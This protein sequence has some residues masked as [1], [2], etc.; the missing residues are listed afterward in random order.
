MYKTAKFIYSVRVTL[1]ETLSC[2]YH[3]FTPRARRATFLT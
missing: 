3:F 1:L 2:K